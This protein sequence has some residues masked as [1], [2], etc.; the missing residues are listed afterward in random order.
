MSEKRLPRTPITKAV[1]QA[2][3]FVISQV[4]ISGDAPRWMEVRLLSTGEPY[5]EVVRMLGK[6][7]KLVELP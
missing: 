7:V 4:E 2:G 6:R 1:P 5:G 3:D